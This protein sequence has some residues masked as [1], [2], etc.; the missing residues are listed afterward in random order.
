MNVTKTLD[1]LQKVART[2]QTAEAAV[3][4]MDGE[5]LVDM[6]ADLESYVAALKAEVEKS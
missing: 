3:A 2:V 5:L 1:F 4:D 6:V